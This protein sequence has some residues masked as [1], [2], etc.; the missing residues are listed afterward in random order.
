[1]ELTTPRRRHLRRISILHVRFRAAIAYSR[2]DIAYTQTQ[3]VG[4]QTGTQDEQVPPPWGRPTGRLLAADRYER[5]PTLGRHRRE[6]REPTGSPFPRWKITPLPLAGNYE[7]RL[8]FG[9]GFD[10]IMSVRARNRGKQLVMGGQTASS[11][12][13]T[14]LSAGRRV[15]TRRTVIT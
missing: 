4:K 11:P 3:G 12:G 13:G 2:E 14:S 8:G 10:R 7:P 5:P 1:M 15:W 9:R 6:E